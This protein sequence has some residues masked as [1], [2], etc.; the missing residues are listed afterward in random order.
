MSISIR[1]A[2]P[3]DAQNLYRMIR[4]LAIY[5][6]EEA[7]VKVTEADLEQQLRQP[8]PPFGCFIAESD[9]EACG[10]A[11]YFYAY[12]TWEGTQ[13]LYLEDLYV[14]PDYRGGGIGIALMQ[15]LARLALEQEC[16]RF[17]WSVLNWNES[18]INFYEQLGAAPLSEWTRY[19]MDSNA[20]AS[21]N[22]SLAQKTA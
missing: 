1:A 12:S 10:F 13:T 8:R 16:K 9:G 6:K 11:L 20:I 4:E 7:S 14:N 21:L 22:D 2:T 18:A 19:R 17:E 5:E 3:F 15:R